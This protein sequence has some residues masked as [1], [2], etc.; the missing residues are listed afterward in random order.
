MATGGLIG[1][2]E[3]DG[4]KRALDTGWSAASREI[5]NAR[6]IILAAL[7]LLGVYTGLILHW[8]AAEGRG[9]DLLVVI[10]PLFCACALGILLVLQ[11]RRTDQVRRAFVNA[12]SR[13]RGAVEAARCGLWE[14]ALDTDE[15]HMSEVMGAMMG[16]GGAGMVSGQAALANIAVEHQPLVRKALEAA[17][18]QGAFDVSFR[19]V[20]PTTGVARWIDARGKG[21]APA[22]TGLFTRIIGVALDVTDERMAQVR[23]ESAERRLRDAIDS[24]PEAFVLFDRQGRLLQCNETFRDFFAVEAKAL[25]PGARRDLVDHCMS[26]A[27]RAETADP[28]PQDGESREVQLNDGRWL[29]IAERRTSEGG[30]VITAADISVL[31]AQEEV[32]RLNEEKLERLVESLQAAQREAVELNDKYVVEKMRAEEANQAKSE[33]LANMS[34]ELRT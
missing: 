27:I 4:S 15:L 24:V 21:V 13:F 28:N 31:K 9:R 3:R 8:L 34:H 16:W 25:K 5:K 6:L 7:L 33:F 18:R 12:E 20:P 11:D 19:V 32:R 22:E 26:L 17:A 23:A 10:V 29:Q 14:W 1:G 30:A 2:E